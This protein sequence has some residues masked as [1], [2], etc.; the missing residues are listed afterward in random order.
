MRV[1]SLS[2][3]LLASCA[4]IFSTAGNAQDQALVEH[5]SQV[6]DKWCRIWQGEPASPID[7]VGTQK[8]Q[9]RYQGAVPAKLEDRTNLTPE[10]IET[11]VRNGL[12]LIFRKIEVSDEDMEALQAYL[13][14]NNPN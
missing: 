10:F 3:I 8:L 6:Y 4:G 7:M 9:E 11:I 1:K 12:G 2:I 5:G 14:R 13:T